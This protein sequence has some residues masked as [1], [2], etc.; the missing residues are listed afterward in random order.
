MVQL[1]NYRFLVRLY[2]GPHH[3]HASRR[4]PRVDY[5]HFDILVEFEPKSSSEREKARVQVAA[6]AAQFRLQE[7][8]HNY[9]TTRL[10]ARYLYYRYDYERKVNCWE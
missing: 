2:N 7:N 4:I 6:D 5:I 8:A 10:H 3:R 1:W 9:L